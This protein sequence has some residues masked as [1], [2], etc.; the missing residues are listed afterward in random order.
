[1]ILYECRINK[2]DDLS[3][4]NGDSF[5]FS[6]TNKQLLFGLFDL[7]QDKAK[8]LQVQLLKAAKAVKDEAKQRGRSH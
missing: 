7:T 6:L 5:Q 3:Q 4:W 1:M 8:V 2:R